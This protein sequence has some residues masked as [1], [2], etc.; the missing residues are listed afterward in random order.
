MHTRLAVLATVDTFHQPVQWT[1]AQATLQCYPG[2]S[3][4]TL[5]RLTLHTYIVQHLQAPI[6]LTSRRVTESVTR[7]G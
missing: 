1:V 3:T 6:S 4:Y 2:C 7:R 5:A